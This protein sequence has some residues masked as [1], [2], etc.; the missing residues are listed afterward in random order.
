M[1]L[2]LGRLASTV[3]LCVGLF[4]AGCGQALAVTYTWT[5]F[6]NGTYSW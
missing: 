4:G 2:S 6:G 3:L 1:R 5:Q